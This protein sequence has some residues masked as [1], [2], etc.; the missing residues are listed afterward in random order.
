MQ[1]SG[2]DL[3]KLQTAYMRKDPVVVAL[4]RRLTPELV[5]FWEKIDYII[6]WTNIDN[7]PDDILDELA[8]ELHIDWYDFGASLEVKRKLIKNSD[9]VHMRLGTP[10][11]VEQVFRD[12]FGQGDVVEWFDYGGEPG[13]FRLYTAAPLGS[14]DD[15]KRFLQILERVKRKSAW[16]EKLIYEAEHGSQLHMGGLGLVTVRYT[17]PI[18]HQL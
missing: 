5:T 14:A 16:L 17:S 7:Y 12:Y 4:C 11:A 13:Y 10:W 8:W 15:V 1:I 6:D 9:K 2:L 18:Q 3:L